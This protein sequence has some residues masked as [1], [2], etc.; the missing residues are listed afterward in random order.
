ME[1]AKE[2]ERGSGE[3]GL[4]QEDR[5]DSQMY[6]QERKNNRANRDNLRV[7]FPAVTPQYPY[8]PQKRNRRKNS[9]NWCA[10][11]LWQHLLD[12]AYALHESDGGGNGRRCVRF[13][14]IFLRRGCRAWRNLSGD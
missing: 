6:G 11:C 3:R 1:V 7:R 5:D 8:E 10:N 14:V 13:D 2:V 9:L 4:E 12:A